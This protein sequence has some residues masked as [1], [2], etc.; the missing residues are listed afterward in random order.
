MTSDDTCTLQITRGTPPADTLTITKTVSPAAGV[1]GTVFTF[2]IVLDP[3]LEQ[4]NSLVL[5][6]DPIPLQLTNAQL[7]TTIGGRGGGGDHKALAVVCRCTELLDNQST[8]I[9]ISAYRTVPPYCRAQSSKTCSHHVCMPMLHFHARCLSAG[10]CSITSATA[11]RARG[12]TTPTRT[13]VTRN[14]EQRLNELL[15]NRGSGNNRGKQP[16]QTPSAGVRTSQQT[17]TCEFPSVTAPQ[18]IRFTV[19]GNTVGTWVNTATVLAN[20]QTKSSDATVKVV[21]LQF[22]YRCAMKLCLGLDV[23][24]CSA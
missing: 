5:L 23:C 13:T 6:T 21:S 11:R 1:Q 22:A 17:L 9:A 2:T 14:N 7:L 16:Q 15:V 3:G 19:T 8:D 20:D 12:A 18:E 4:V 10:A 24:P